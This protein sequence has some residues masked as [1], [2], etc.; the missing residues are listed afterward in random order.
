VEL[1]EEVVAA[2][3]VAADWEEVE[4]VEA[5]RVELVEEVLAA[6]VAA[7]VAD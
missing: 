7:A 5:A 1:V 2:A 6:A 4:E 3:V